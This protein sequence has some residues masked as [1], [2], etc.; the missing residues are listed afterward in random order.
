LAVSN[1][2]ASLGLHLA[3]SRE[4]GSGEDGH[5]CAACHR[6][7]PVY[8]ELGVRITDVG[9]AGATTWHYGGSPEDDLFI[10]NAGIETTKLFGLWEAMTLKDVHDIGLIDVTDSV[11]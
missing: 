4:Q 10:I 1:L 6:R 8:A 2:V 11:K 7:L 3:V 9:R 5:V